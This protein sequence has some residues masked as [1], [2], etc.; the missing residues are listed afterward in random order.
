MC[1]FLEYSYDPSISGVGDKAF[2]NAASAV[3]Q[4]PV[5]S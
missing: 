4:H 3:R 5:L 1:R 2:E